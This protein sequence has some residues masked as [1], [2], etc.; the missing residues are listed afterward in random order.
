MACSVL[1]WKT[2]STVLAPSPKFA[3]ATPEYAT[4]RTE[5]KD[6]KTRRALAM[7][8]LAVCVLP[9]PAVPRSNKRSDGGAVRDW[10]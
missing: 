3:A 5:W 9:V 7:A 6:P 4:V 10:L 2:L 8:S 1:V